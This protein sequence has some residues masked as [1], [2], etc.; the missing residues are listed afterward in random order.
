VEGELDQQK[1]AIRQA[2][3]TRDEV[4]P[5]LNESDLND[6]WEREKMYGEM[7]ALQWLQSKYPLAATNQ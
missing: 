2:L 3:E 7:Y 5:T 1:Q 4:R 6:Y